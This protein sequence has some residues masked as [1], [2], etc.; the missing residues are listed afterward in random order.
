MIQFSTSNVR[1][2]LVVNIRDV[3]NKLELEPKV[4]PHEPANN[5]R[6][7]IIPRMP[8]VRMIVYCRAADIP[9]DFTLLNWHKGD[10][11]SWL[12][13]V[14]DFQLIHYGGRGGHNLSKGRNMDRSEGCGELDTRR[15][16]HSAVAHGPV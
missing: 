5:I 14:V 7:D 10:W 1:S 15:K 4:I 2:Y 9:F 16:N 8:Q 3:H 13:G 12:Q 6:R 11:S